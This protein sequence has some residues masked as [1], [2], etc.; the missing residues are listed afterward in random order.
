M[1]LI[2]VER[3]QKYFCF[4]DLTPFRKI[5]SDLPV[6]QSLAGWVVDVGFWPNKRDFIRSPFDELLLTFVIIVVGKDV[7]VIGE[8]HQGGCP[9][10]QGGLKRLAP[11][12]GATSARFDPQAAVWF[13]RPYA[14]WQ[15]GCSWLPERMVVVRRQYFDRSYV[16]LPMRGWSST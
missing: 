4:W 10:S 6:G 14:G 8:A 9:Q 3:K 15:S 12:A 7:V 1:H 13:A 5:R 16:L 2:W 11:R